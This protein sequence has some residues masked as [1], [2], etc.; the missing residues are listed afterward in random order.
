MPTKLTS[1]L[2]RFYYRD[3]YGNWHEIDALPTI[4]FSVKIS[5]SSPDHNA[6]ETEKLTANMIP[7][8]ELAITMNQSKS[9][10]KILKEHIKFIKS[11][12]RHIRREKRIKEQARRAKLKWEALHQ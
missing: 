7:T 10:R 9:V 2:G 11:L 1:V 4:T 12:N 3:G 8:S 6:E 5:G